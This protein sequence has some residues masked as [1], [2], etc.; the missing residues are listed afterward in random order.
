ML[1]VK[2]MLREKEVTQMLEEQSE[3]EEKLRGAMEEKIKLQSVEY[4]KKERAQDLQ[5]I[6]REQ[7]IRQNEEMKRNALQKKLEENSPRV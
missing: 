4:G 2:E 3:Q 5:Q 1:R 7:A 6:Q